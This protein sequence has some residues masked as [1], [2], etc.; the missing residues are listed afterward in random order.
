MGNTREDTTATQFSYSESLLDLENSVKRYDI[1]YPR[2][3]RFENGII[4]CGPKKDAK[5]KLQP[6]VYH[7]SISH[8]KT[9]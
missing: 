2:S 1:K 7:K 8:L 5:G 3:C 6:I 9:E 4:S